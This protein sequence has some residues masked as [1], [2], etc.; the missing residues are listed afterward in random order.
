MLLSP[1]GAGKACGAAK[2]QLPEAI[3]QP[4]HK[5]LSSQKVTQTEGDFCVTL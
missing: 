1:Q 4:K 5:A 2:S 3:N